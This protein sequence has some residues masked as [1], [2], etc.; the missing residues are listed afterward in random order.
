MSATF[1][2]DR[3]APGELFIWTDIA[4]EHEQDFNQ[5][6]EREHM[7]E[8]AAIP[9][10][11]WSRRYVRQGAGRK[12]LALYRTE[13]LRVFGTADYKKAFE[14][15]TDWSIANFGRMSNTQRRVMAVSLLG[16]AGTG[17]VVLLVRLADA[18]QLDELARQSAAY[19]EQTDGLL[20]LRVL[21][22]DP[23][24][25]T[26][27]PSEDVRQRSLD[28]YLVADLTTVS[29]ARTLVARLQQDLGVATNDVSEFSLLWDLQS[30]DLNAGRP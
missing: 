1:R 13:S 25:S 30:R 19:L 2:T 17:S 27:L 3:D 29:A 23:E 26:P 4:P 9:G 18:V 12:Y 28:P 24:L 7:A 5:W 6:Y 10:F 11:Q 14:R 22:P 21:T 8:R 15:Q 16:G 20:A